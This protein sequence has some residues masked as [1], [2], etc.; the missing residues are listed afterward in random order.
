MGLPTTLQQTCLRLCACPVLAAGES[1]YSACVWGELW[2]T[3]SKGVAICGSLRERAPL[4]CV[5]TQGVRAQQFS[6]WS[7]FMGRALRS[8]DDYDPPAHQLATRGYSTSTSPAAAKPCLGW[9]VRI[10]V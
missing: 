6:I 5:N 1:L 2:E 7:L 3:R 4:S 10:G 9:E 8:K